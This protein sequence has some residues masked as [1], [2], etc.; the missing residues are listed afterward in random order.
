MRCPNFIPR[1]RRAP[2]PPHI[3]SA[4]SPQGKDWVCAN[5]PPRRGVLISYRRG[6]SRIARRFRGGN[7]SFS[8]RLPPFSL[9]LSFVFRVAEDVDPYNCVV[10]TYR[11]AARFWFLRGRGGVSPPAVSVAVIVRFWTVEDAGP[12]KLCCAN[13]P[14]RREIF[15]FVCRGDQWSPAFSEQSPFVFGR[16]M[17][18][19]T[20]D[21]CAN[22]P[23]R[24]EVSAFFVSLLQREKGDHDSGG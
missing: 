15:N 8:A 13:K 1:K 14:P 20:V 23:P 7:R 11:Y 9:R 19:P 21:L 6:D 10:Q 3:S 24:R 22:I 17:V 4:P 16:P 18:A 2:H 5:K 12:Y